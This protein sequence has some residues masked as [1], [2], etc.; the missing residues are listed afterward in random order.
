MS[1]LFSI[2]GGGGMHIIWNPRFSSV[3]A[4]NSNPLRVISDTVPLKGCSVKV[5]VARGP[6]WEGSTNFNQERHI[7]LQTIGQCE[8]ACLP[9]C[10]HIQA[11][12]LSSTNESRIFESKQ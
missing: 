7:H 4:P 8:R 3:V 12:I 5:G 9:L 2:G 1:A 6:E 10:G 11:K